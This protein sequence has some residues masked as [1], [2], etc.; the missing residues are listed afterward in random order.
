VE[1]VVPFEFG[2]SV[3]FQLLATGRASVGYAA[4]GDDA[5]MEGRADVVVQGALQ[6][7]YVPDALGAPTAPE[8][9][10]TGVG[11]GALAVL[12]IRASPR[13]RRRAAIAR[14]GA[15]AIAAPPESCG[16]ERSGGSEKHTERAGSERSFMLSAPVPS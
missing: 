9:S 15:M 6:P 13:R 12:A 14:F 8:P 1:L 2:Q 10:S 11:A 16:V 3:T 7:A 5:F 4:N